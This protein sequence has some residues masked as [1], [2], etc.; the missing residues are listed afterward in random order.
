MGWDHAV[1]SGARAISGSIDP[2]RKGVTVTIRYRLS[3]EDVWNGLTTVQT[4]EN[5]QYS[6]VWAPESA[7]NYEIKAS[8]EG[9]KNTFA[10]ET[11]VQGLTVK[12]AGPNVPLSLIAVVVAI[13]LMV[14]IVA[15]FM[16]ARKTV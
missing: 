8:W 16:R 3:G 4:D 10:S 12:E 2:I 6:Y 13:I 15:Y 14:I 9:D 5:I 7:G 11:E 1:N